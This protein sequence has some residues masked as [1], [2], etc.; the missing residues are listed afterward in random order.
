MAFFTPALRRLAFQGPS[1][2]FVCNQCLRQQSPRRPPSTI[3]HLV[4]SHGYAGAKATATT[5]PPLNSLASRAATTR[6][7]PETTPKG[8]AYWLMGSAA[9]VFGIVVFGGL[10]RLTESGLSITEWRPVTGSLP[11]IC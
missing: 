1:R 7:F 6:V 4:R 9:S 10:T 8:V 11:P 5:P 3:L 2:F